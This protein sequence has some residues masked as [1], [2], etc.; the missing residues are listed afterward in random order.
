MT[1]IIKHKSYLLLSLFLLISNAPSKVEAQVKRQ[2]EGS[3]TRVQSVGLE[4]GWAYPE[5]SLVRVGDYIISVGGVS[6]GMEGNA[7]HRAALYRIHPK[8]TL[9]FVQ[10]LAVRAAG[11]SA[12]GRTV[13]AIAFDGGGLTTHIEVFE[14]PDKTGPM[15]IDVNKKPP[16]Q[17]TRYMRCLTPLAD[18]V[19]VAETL[20]PG[21]SETDTVRL[22]SSRADQVLA[23]HRF[24]KTRWFVYGA[25]RP[26]MIMS[27]A[28]NA[29]ILA[30]RLAGGRVRLLDLDNSL[31]PRHDMKLNGLGAVT[32]SGQ[33]LYAYLTNGTL[34]AYDVSNPDS[35]AQLWSRSIPRVP[36]P[37]GIVIDGERIIVHGTGLTEAW[38]NDAHPPTYFRVNYKWTTLE[39]VIANGDLIYAF[40]NGGSVCKV[41]TLKLV[42]PR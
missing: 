33:T 9:G 27:L 30:A 20:K 41:M 22:L 21:N 19:A 4:G 1:K 34:Q 3:L 40:N 15:R 35:P 25:I 26:E 32:L 24:K 42:R 8:G 38:T 6:G 18:G 2:R 17:Y 11:L 12:K 36:N 39:C 28:A 13:Y 7:Y 31:K 10:K 5:Q 14:L 37:K 16:L 29:R 23:T